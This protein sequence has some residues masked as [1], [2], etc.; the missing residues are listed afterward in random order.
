[1]CMLAD[2]LIT[3]LVELDLRKLLDL[4][5]IVLWCQSTYGEIVEAGDEISEHDVRQWKG[6]AG[7]NGRND[8]YDV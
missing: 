4:L 6:H 5:H 7:C 1:M 3:G 8:G 2:F